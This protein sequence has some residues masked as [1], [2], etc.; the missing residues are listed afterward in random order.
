VLVQIA[1]AAR[2]LSDDRQ[3][4]A[5]ALPLRWAR[6][7]ELDAA[8]APLLT[9]PKPEIARKATE[10]IG[11]RLRKRGGPAEPLLAALKSPTRSSPSSPPRASRSPAAAR[12]S[13]SC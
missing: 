8:L 9:Y 12:A 11:W 5:I 10:A 13:A 4:Q 2:R 3:L 1:E 6:S 7:K